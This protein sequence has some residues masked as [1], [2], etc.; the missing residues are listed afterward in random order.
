MKESHYVHSPLSPTLKIL[1]PQQITFLKFPLAFL[2][3]GAPVSRIICVT[4]D[5]WVK[6]KRSVSG[7]EIKW[8]VMVVRIDGDDNCCEVS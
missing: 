2:G 8:V 3:S 6:D 5:I 1:L 4:K 7:I